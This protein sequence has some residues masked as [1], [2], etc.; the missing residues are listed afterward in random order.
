MLS[1]SINKSEVLYYSH[2]TQVTVSSPI[3]PIYP[4]S[5]DLLVF[6]T[7]H[8]NL[9]PTLSPIHNLLLDDGFSHSKFLLITVDWLLHGVARDVE[10]ALRGPIDDPHPVRAVG[11]GHDHFDLLLI[12]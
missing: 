12:D 6:F 7:F 10:F 5:L 4:N 9:Q 3:S 1:I 11:A 8:T 2:T